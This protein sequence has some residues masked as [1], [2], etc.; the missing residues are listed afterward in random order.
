MNKENTRDNSSKILH[1]VP[2]HKATTVSSLI[3]EH[4]Q[5]GNKDQTEVSYVQVII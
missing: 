4:L 1:A 2:R 5:C 3:C